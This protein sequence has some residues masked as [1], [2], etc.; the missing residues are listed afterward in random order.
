MQQIEESDETKQYQT[1]FVC[2]YHLLAN[3]D[4]A[5]VLYQ[6]QFLQA[7]NLATF[8]DTVINSITEELFKNFGTN[9]LIVKLMSLFDSFWDAEIRFRLCFS[10]GSFHALHRILCALITDEKL[11]EDTVENLF[12][13][14]SV[15]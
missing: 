7:F 3:A 11:E 4:E 6:M 9:E 1:D 14:I 8:N 5:E 2:T 10:Y 12:S 13:R 15:E